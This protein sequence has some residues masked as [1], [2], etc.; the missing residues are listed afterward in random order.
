MTSKFK[1]ALSDL[2]TLAELRS[3]EELNAKI[4]KLT[5]DNEVKFKFL[6]THQLEETYNFESLQNLSDP[7]LKRP[8]TDLERLD[9]HEYQ[10]P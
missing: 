1:G 10:R 9:L 4:A 3:K 7:D 5:T 6:F 8:L 2:G